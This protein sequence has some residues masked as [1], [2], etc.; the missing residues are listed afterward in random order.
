MQGVH[1]LFCKTFK[2]SIFL[3]K[4]VKHNMI[5]H[6]DQQHKQQNVR[7]WL[8]EL[9]RKAPCESSAC[10][11]QIKLNLDNFFCLVSNTLIF[12]FILFSLVLSTLGC[13]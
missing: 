8:T 9:F 4:I 1:Q 6:M 11:G 5:S 2:K 10:N 12:R 3:K 13:L 7:V